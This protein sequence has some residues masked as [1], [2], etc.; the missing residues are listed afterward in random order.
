MAV[1]EYKALKSGGQTTTGI[2]NADSPR[3]ARDTLRSQG[4]YVTDIRESGARGGKLLSKVKVPKFLSRRKL[5]EIALIT[6]QLATLLDSGLPLAQA[7]VAM[8]DQAENKGVERMLRDV[9]DKV[10][11]GI[12]FAEAIKHHPIYFSDLYVSMIR[13][14]E[15]TGN[16]APVL[17]RLADFSQNQNR[18]QARISAALAYPIVMIVVAGGVVAFLMA[19]VVPKIQE[20]IVREGNTLPLPTRILLKTS[21]II[22][23]YWWV[24]LIGLFLL[25][26][27]YKFIRSTKRGHYVIDKFHMMVPVLGELYRKQSVSRFAATFAS[28]IGTGVPVIEALG[29]VE[30]VV[31]NRV[32]SDTIAKMR[33]R[34]S[35]G[36]DIST[37]IKRSGVFPPIVGYMVA[38]GEESG[39]LEEILNR[40]S[41]SYNEEIEISSQKLTSLLEP[42]IILVMAGI[43][44]FIVISILLPLL[45]MS[46]LS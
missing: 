6:R 4:L 30:G 15:E 27:L 1:Y 40:L 17:A 14:A 2:L 43:V 34:I 11:Q 33:T 35:E 31:G 18:I 5:Q 9:R 19:F 12:S 21:S 29:V 45:S 8:V 41:V 26:A 25:S 32:L 10:T 28:L 7:L 24:M 36:A 46:K 44:A 39:R 13:A 20:V 38:I 37:P 16:L 42:I 3:D 22:A 23:S